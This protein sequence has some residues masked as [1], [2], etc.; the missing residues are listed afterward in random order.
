M[1]GNTSK[2]EVDGTTYWVVTKPSH[3]VIYR[4]YGSANY[5]RRSLAWNSKRNPAPKPGSKMARVL[6]TTDP[7]AQP[8]PAAKSESHN[9]SEGGR[10][11]G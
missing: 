10:D 7:G 9:H 4:R 3:T 5:P 1:I 2:V 8:V 11:V 6:A